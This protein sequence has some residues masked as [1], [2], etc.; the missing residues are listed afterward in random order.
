MLR[1]AS[2]SWVMSRGHPADARLWRLAWSLIAALTSAD[3]RRAF[4]PGP[5]V[6]LVS[7]RPAASRAQIRAQIWL[8]TFVFQL[9]QASGTVRVGRE[10]EQR[11]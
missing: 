4:I 1:L 8:L 5:L 11:D 9:Y 7:S 2:D 10:A 3:G 6:S